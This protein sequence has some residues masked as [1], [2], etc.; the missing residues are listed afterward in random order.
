MQQDS[1]FW[2]GGVKVGVGAEG[3]SPKLSKEKHLLKHHGL[4][5]QRQMPLSPGDYQ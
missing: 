2:R 3:D 5:Y 1:F 4:T